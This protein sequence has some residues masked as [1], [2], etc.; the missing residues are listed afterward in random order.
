[1]TKTLDEFLAEHKPAHFVQRYDLKKGDRVLALPTDSYRFQHI[2][3]EGRKGTIHF[4]GSK[5]M[6]VHLDGDSAPREIGHR[7]A[8]FLRLKEDI[9]VE[10]EHHNHVKKL[11]DGGRGADNEE[12]GPKEEMYAA[13]HVS[14]YIEKHK[15]H[16]SAVQSHDA[17]RAAGH[18]RR[19]NQ[20]ATET[21]DYDSM[22]FH[23][24]EKWNHLNSLHK[25]LKESLT[26]SIKEPHHVINDKTGKHIHTYPTGTSHFDIKDDVKKWSSHKLNTHAV[27]S[28]SEA[29]ELKIGPYHDKDH[30]ERHMKESLNEDIQ[31]GHVVKINSPGSKHHGMEGEY[32]GV[33]HN[34]GMDKKHQVSVEHG[35]RHFGSFHFHKHELTKVKNSVYESDYWSKTIKAHKK[36]LDKE[37][38]ASTHY[39]SM[40]VKH[41]NDW[42]HHSDSDTKDDHTAERDSLRHTHKAKDIKTIKV[43]KDEADWRNPEHV[44]KAKA[45]LNEEI[46]DEAKM[47]KVSFDSM[48]GHESVAAL[49]KVG[50]RA[51]FRDGEGGGDYVVDAKYHNHQKPELR[52]HLVRHYGDESEAKELHPHIFKEEILTEESLTS[53][54]NKLV[55]A[56]RLRKMSKA[57]PGN[58]AYYNTVIKQLLGKIRNWRG[59]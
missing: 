8:D 4:V 17:D 48:S 29:K 16:F 30:H 1:M 36:A 41:G 19:Y 37:S 5:H 26:E 31:P 12:H 23:K 44:A 40:W 33:N 53:L 39:R 28:D 47:K 10:N 55:S 57:S 56:R 3:K 51:T 43:H 35:G 18:E 21:K 38:K 59:G 58:L 27:F 42:H 32:L 46:L 15:K 20:H 50:I 11:I 6:K 22:H 9:L 7:D 25:S 54:K 14:D 24:T 45:K 52:K 13:K 49:K 2:P 34:S